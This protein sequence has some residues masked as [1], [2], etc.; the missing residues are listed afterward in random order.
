VE[1][2]KGKDS[3]ESLDLKSGKRLDVQGIFIEIGYKPNQEISKSLGL[4]TTESNYIE[5]N[6]KQETS[7]EGVYAAGDITNNPLKQ[8][9]TA[10][11]EGAIAADSAY[12]KISKEKK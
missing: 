1:K 5:V 12:K 8:V 2:I 11:S 7:I 3:V 9:I 10:C 4:K 6:K